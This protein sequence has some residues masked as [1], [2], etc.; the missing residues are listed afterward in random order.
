MLYEISSRTLQLTE[1][2]RT[3]NERQNKQLDYM[4]MQSNILTEEHQKLN[5]VSLDINVRTGGMET[6]VGV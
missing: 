4:E 1:N 3:E 2:F 5:D 6:R